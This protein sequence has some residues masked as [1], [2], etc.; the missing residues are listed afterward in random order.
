MVDEP[1]TIITLDLGQQIARLNQLSE[2]IQDEMQRSG[3][4]VPVRASQCLTQLRV[5]L[6]KLGRQVA[7]HNDELKN[8]R[9]LADISRVVNSS[10]ELTE[11]LR[12]VMDTIVRL[13][14]AER[15]F[16]MLRGVEGD[17]NADC[18]NWEQN[19]HPSEFAI[20]RTI[21][22]RVVAEREPLLTTNARGTSLRRAGKY[23]CPYALFCASVEI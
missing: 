16:L 5:S 3:A 12:I 10:L 23:Y 20:S 8:L 13:T 4:P 21:I 17:N 6:A 22:D 19:H 2:Q 15:G 7:H 9:A 1:T 14:G 18:R 11:V